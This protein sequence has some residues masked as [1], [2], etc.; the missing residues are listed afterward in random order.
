[1]ITL[2]EYT[3]A[4]EQVQRAREMMLFAAVGGATS[5]ATALLWR[6]PRGGRKALGYVVGVAVFAAGMA[7]MTYYLAVRRRDTTT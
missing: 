5:A 7:G 6:D 3:V 2:A 1:M 4:A